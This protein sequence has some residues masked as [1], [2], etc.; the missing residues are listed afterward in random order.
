MPD[1]YFKN[2]DCRDFNF[3]VCEMNENILFTTPPEGTTRFY[4]LSNCPFEYAVNNI[5][6]F[7]HQH[8]KTNYT[9]D[10]S[11]YI[12]IYLHIWIYLCSCHLHTVLSRKC[13]CCSPLKMNF[14]CDI[15]L[16]NILENYIT[17]PNFPHHYPHNHDEV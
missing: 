8:K 3:F 7:Q 2:E 4:K 5:S 11:K 12:Y 14:D 17:S 6:F 16:L 10:I 13:I 9:L 1:G 15:C